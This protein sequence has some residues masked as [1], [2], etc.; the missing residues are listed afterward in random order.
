MT[1]GTEPVAGL[2]AFREGAQLLSRAYGTH[3]YTFGQASGVGDAYPRSMSKRCAP[4][5]S[6]KKAPSAGPGA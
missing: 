1:R 6:T 5:I 4:G 3:A 2:V